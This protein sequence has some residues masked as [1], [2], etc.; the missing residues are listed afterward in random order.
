MIS[1]FHN[2]YTKVNNKEAKHLSGFNIQCHG[3]IKPFYPSN[4]VYFWDCYNICIAWALS[5]IEMGYNFY[6]ADY[7]AVSFWS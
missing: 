3:T 2:I 4:K 7:T 1:T 5:E 6:G